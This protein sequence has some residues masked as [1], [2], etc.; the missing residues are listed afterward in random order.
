MLRAHHM[1]SKVHLLHSPTPGQDP[2][3]PVRE[4]VRSQSSGARVVLEQARHAAEAPDSANWTFDKLPSGAPAPH[5]DWYWSISHDAVRVAAAVYQGPIGVDLERIVLR[6]QALVERVLKP[7]EWD[8]FVG[9]EALAFTRAWTA[10]EAV[11]KAAGV[12]LAELRKCRVTRVLDE[13][14]LLLSH[15]EQ[16]LLVQQT[17]F[18][19]HVLAVHVP[20]HDW[21]VEWR[22]VPAPTDLDPS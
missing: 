10:K 21:E 6:R 12:G 19:N 8:L 5:G 3:T 20:G 1:Q 4:R 14:R 7:E 11:L 15:R 2:S 18:E 16:K 17:R 9:D 13:H 22:A